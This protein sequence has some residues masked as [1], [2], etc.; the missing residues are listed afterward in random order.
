MRLEH[1]SAASTP[2]TPACTTPCAS[3][4]ANEERNL[5]A[6]NPDVVSKMRSRLAELADPKNGYRHPQENIPDPR[7]IPPLHNGTWGPFRKTDARG[8]EEHAP[9]SAEQEQ[10]AL[11]AVPS[12]AVAFWD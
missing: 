7:G 2:L 8:L 4:A 11:A 6:A 5:A 9:M 10:A 1:T 3:L 12:M